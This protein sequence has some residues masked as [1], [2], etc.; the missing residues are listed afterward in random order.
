M[1]QM[2]REIKTRLRIAPM[3]MA[4]IAP[5]FEI[6]SGKAVWSRVVAIISMVL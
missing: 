3:V 5:P 4:V 1:L 2:R 6:A